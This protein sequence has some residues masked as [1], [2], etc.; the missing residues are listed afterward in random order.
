M[1]RKDNLE[2]MLTGH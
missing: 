1:G 2:P